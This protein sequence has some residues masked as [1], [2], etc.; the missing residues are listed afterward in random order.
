MAGGSVAGIYG[1][2]GEDTDHRSPF[3]VHSLPDPDTTRSSVSAADS[4]VNALIAKGDDFFR[5]KKYDQ[6]LKEYREAQK[7]RFNDPLLKEKAD[8]TRRIIEELARTQ[9]EYNKAVASADAYF[10]Q[11]DYLNAKAAYQLALNLRPDDD[12][13]NGRMKETL[14]LLR[15]QKAKNILYDVAIASAEKLFAAGEYDKA[16]I[17]FENAGKI[18]PTE[19]YPKERINEIIRIQAERQTREE[20]Y[21]RAIAAADKF[22]TAKKYP[23]ALTEYKNAAS[24]KPEETYPRDR[25]RELE[26]LIAGMKE[27]DEAYKKAIANGDRLF[28]AASYTDSRNEFLNASKIKPEE[29]YPKKKIKEIDDLLAA[30]KRMSDEYQRLVDAG[31]SLYIARSYLLARLKYEQASRVRPGEAYPKEMI[32]KAENLLSSQEANARTLEEAY[33][34]ILASADRMFAGKEYERARTEY[35]NASSIKPEEQY[36][37][38]RIAE[39]DAIAA[40]TASQ[41]AEDEKYLGIVAAADSLLAEKQYERARS[42]YGNALKIKPAEQYPK[43]RIAEIGTILGDLA[44]RKAKD[45]Q[46]ARI[47]AN[48]DKL[49]SEKV[50]PQSKAQFQQALEIKPEEVYPKEKISEI[51]KILADAA[52]Q[53][54]LDEQYRSLL[55]GADKLFQEKTYDKAK[56]EYENAL[57]LRP[58]DPYPRDRIA[59]IDKIF[60]ENALRQAEQE[61]YA[62]ILARADSLLGNKEYEPAKTEYSLALGMRPKEQYPRTRIAEI[63]GILAGI[64]RQKALEDQYSEAIASGDRLLAARSYPDARIQYETAL[65]LKPGEQYPKDKIAE[66]ETALDLLARQKA[67]DDQYSASLAKAD[68]LF[69]SQSWEPAKAEYGH[70]LELKPSEEYPKTRIAEIT[71]I[72]ADLADQKARDEMYAAGIAKADKLLSEKAYEPAKTEYGSALAIKPSE[73]YPKAKIAEIDG[74]LAGIAEQKARDEKYASGIARADKLLADKSFEAAK[75]EYQD[76]SALKPAEEYPKTKIAA[77]DRILEEQARLKALDAQYSALVADGDRLLA[78]KFYL[79]AKPKYQAALEL[80]PAEAYPKEKLAEIDQALAAIA[81][82]KAIDDQYTLAIAGADKLFA[83]K[84]YEASRT[85]YLNAGKIK[86]AEQYPKDK[87]AEIE[88]ILAAIA[89]QKVIDEKYNAAIANADKLFDAKTYEQAKTEYTNAGKLKPEA[90]YPK[91]KLAAIEGI[92]AGIA[93]QRE[94]DEQYKVMVTKADQLLLAKSYEQA[95]TEFTNALNLKPAEEYPKSKIA[96]IEKILSDQK[97]LDDRYNAAIASADKLL[98]EKSYDEARTEYLN[99]QKIKPSEQYPKDKVAEIDRTLGEIARQKAVDDQYAASVA[100]ADK[101]LAEKSYQQARAEFVSAQAIKPAETY[102]RDKIA[103]IDGIVAEILARNEKYKASVTKA[104]QLFVQKSW[105]EARTEYQN[106]SSIKPEERY[107]KDK[108]TEINKILAELK[109][110]RQT[111]DDLVAQGDNQFSMKEF[112]R[113][114][115]FFEQALGLFPDESYPKNRIN[116]INAITDS[117]FRA[118]KVFYDKAVAE[119]DRYYNSLVFDRAIDSY[120][121]A[122]SYLPMEPYPREMINRIKRIIT[123][124]AIVDVLKSTLLIPAGTE[125]KFSFTPV[126][127][128]SRKNNYFYIKIRNLGDKPFNVLVRYGKDSQISGGAVLRNLAADGNIYDRLISVKDQDPWYRED[129]NWIGLVP[130]GGDVEV[131]FIQIS[132]SQ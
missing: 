59:Q 52:A 122:Q 28:A 99:A 80:K 54:T 29:G 18:L 91:D 20:M 27:R 8:R 128:A 58:E 74:I 42:E 96:V 131:S 110:K 15:S 2:M 30:Q 17:E 4:I 32:S 88:K 6:A 13:A 34:T 7:Y 37:K 77:I 118:N 22:Y 33:R 49:F 66:I 24:S 64:A 23:S 109:G 48:A 97:A 103:E 47:I 93:R 86:P 56:A 25:I 124:N 68:R 126:D 60:E 40:A 76:A 55:A 53:K 92:L 1:R 130:Q 106:A 90:Q 63:D 111:F 14:E 116:R 43:D 45:D 21:A 35:Q 115:E 79:E 71:K 117:L 57:T 98:A 3:P 16:R 108:M 50:Y 102:P 61:R 100:R 125:K 44:A 129:N 73:E 10:A 51:D 132:R 82:Q 78:D 113:S 36:P 46:Y 85:G 38:D 83:E 105:E 127:I 70:A 26:I 107:P 65:K 39:I 9:P 81:K 69:A 101:Y 11:K 62:S 123:E 104:D 121:E 41:K 67:L 12:Y 114:K 89:A 72:L 75:A 84:S 95:K 87:V 19:Q 120:S 5:Q 119:G 31:D 94:I 112:Y